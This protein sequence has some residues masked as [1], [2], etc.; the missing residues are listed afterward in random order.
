V[1]HFVGVGDGGIGDALVLEL[2]CV[3]KL[4]ALGVLDVAVMCAIIVDIGLVE[5]PFQHTCL[6]HLQDC[7]VN[8][9]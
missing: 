4:F 8:G 5:K 1:H 2:H 9:N 6:Y 7:V 3:G